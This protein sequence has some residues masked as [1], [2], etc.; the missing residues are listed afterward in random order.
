MKKFFYIFFLSMFSI[1]YTASASAAD[2]L[3]LYDPPETDWLM[4]N[5]MVPLFTP[6]TSPF[7]AVSGIFLGGVLTLGGILAAYTIILGTIN[8]AHEGEVLG[9]RWS[10]LY[11]PIRTAI[12]IAM[13]MPIKSGF[14]TIQIII[15]WLATQGIGFADKAWDAWADDPLKG[16]VLISPRLD[17]VLEPIY[18]QAVRAGVCE[19]TISNAINKAKSQGDVAYNSLKYSLSSTGSLGSEV[20]GMSSKSV[21]TT[22]RKNGVQYNFGFTDGAPGLNTID[23]KSICGS[24]VLAGVDTQTSGLANTATSYGTYYN[25]YTDNNVA[26]VSRPESLK[27]DLIDIDTVKTA[28]FAQQSTSLPAL[29][30]AGETLG[31]SIANTPDISL[32]SIANQMKTDIAIY[33]QDLSAIAKSSFSEALDSSMID[34]M[35]ADGFISAGTWFYRVSV[36]QQAVNEQFA[37]IPVVKNDLAVSN[38]TVIDP[39]I[40]AKMDSID[41]VMSEAGRKLPSNKNIDT[42]D[43]SQMANIVVNTVLNSSGLG[44][45]D[46]GAM[47]GN[48]L[49]VATNLGQNMIVGVGSA[50][51]AI[52]VILFGIGVAGGNIFGKAIGTDLAVVTGVTLLT[53]YIYMILGTLMAPALY[54]AVYFPLIPFIIW[55]GAAIGWLVLV[56]EA[57]FA[58]PLWAMAHMAP[59]ADSVVGRQGQGYMLILS[60]ILR[61]ILMV[62]GFVV[63]L[64][65]LTPA[66]IFVNYFFGF[67]VQGVAGNNILVEFMTAAGSLI[68]YCLLMNNLVKKILSLIHSIPDGLLQWIGGRQ[69]HLLGEYADG[70]EGSTGSGQRA[71]LGAMTGA[72]SGTL[73]MVGKKIDS[74]AAS[75]R[76]A[77]Q[78][79]NAAAKSGK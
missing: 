45:Q 33:Q 65:L 3:F 62:I 23:P 10:T 61:P 74:K 14:C 27:N 70:I 79:R 31:R 36:A 24:F 2:F 55:T 15:I 66:A 68:I 64:N 35:K 30:Q 40:K 12:G 17:S 8:T 73:G 6:E 7:G 72:A 5:I 51:A 32:S 20:L 58:G 29:L 78:E 57:L 47:T 38:L 9:K 67:M 4:K 71:A 13:I 22:G 42:K 11:M 59:D 44:S 75:A 63:A 25:V 19:Q 26:N 37:N 28:L 54:L 34:K 53:P 41:K 21:T 56:V 43:P 69:S 48:P 50:I 52:S 77:A 49:Y 76:K 39:N 16:S 1:F 60:L 46:Y 18:V